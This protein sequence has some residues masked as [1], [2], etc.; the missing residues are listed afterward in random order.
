MFE[1]PEPPARDADMDPLGE[2]LAEGLGANSNSQSQQE[3]EPV[4]AQRDH[5]PGT[6]IKNPYELPEDKV[7]N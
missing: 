6:D 5:E 2:D 7:K 1:E 4:Y 3:E